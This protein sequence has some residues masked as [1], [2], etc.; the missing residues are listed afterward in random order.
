MGPLV[1]GPDRNCALF[2]LDFERARIVKAVY[3]CTT[4]VTLV[5]FCEHLSELVVGMPAER[6]LKLDAEHL[7][8]HHREVPAGRR[9]RAFLAV[10]ALKIAVQYSIQRNYQ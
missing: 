4:C 7:L 5:A 6:A 1:Y 10:N 2:N 9:D 8:R 3:R